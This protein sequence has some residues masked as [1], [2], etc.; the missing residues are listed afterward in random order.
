MEKQ[1]QIVLNYL[2]EKGKKKRALPLVN[3]TSYILG[4]GGL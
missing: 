2:K 3:G 1:Y 4:G